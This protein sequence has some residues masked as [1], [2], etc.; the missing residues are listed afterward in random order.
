M[1]YLGVLLRLCYFPVPMLRVI[2]HALVTTGTACV[3]WAVLMCVASAIGMYVYM[4]LSPVYRTDS[5]IVPR[6]FT[7]PVDRFI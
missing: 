1:V 2:G 6:S 3:D 7:V 5:F 4:V